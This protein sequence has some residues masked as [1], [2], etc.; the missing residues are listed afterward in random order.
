MY[1]TMELFS[2][3]VGNFSRHLTRVKSEDL[4]SC[5][6]LLLL[7]VRSA[8]QVSGVVHGQGSEYIRILMHGYLIPFIA[9]LKIQNYVYSAF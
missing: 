4:M 3:L 1:M 6:Y 9:S 2:D 5:F 8:R 7:T